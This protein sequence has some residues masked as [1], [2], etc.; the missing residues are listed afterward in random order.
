MCVMYM[1]CILILV[2]NRSARFGCVEVQWENFDAKAKT[3]SR[4]DKLLEGIVFENWKNEMEV[5]NEIDK[6]IITSR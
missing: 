5:W 1:V 3:G 6:V 2:W 4:C